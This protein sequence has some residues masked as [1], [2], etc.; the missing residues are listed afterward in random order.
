M[1]AVRA[2]WLVVLACLAVLAVPPHARAAR[3]AP[4]GDS[5]VDQYYE[6][7]P[8]GCNAPSPRC[9]AARARP[10]HLSPGELRQLSSDGLAGRAVS[11]LVSS[12]APAIPRGPSIAPNAAGANPVVSLGGLMVTGSTG[13]G[14]GATRSACPSSG[15]IGL[16]LPILLAV[17]LAGAIAVVVIRRTGGQASTAQ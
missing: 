16:L 2:A 10:R 13:G 9:E 3:C 8:G 1:E 12:S 6:T 15:G 4:P 17:T 5:S 11:G 7:I 14:G